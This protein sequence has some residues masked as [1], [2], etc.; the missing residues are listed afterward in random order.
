MNLNPM[1][2]TFRPPSETVKKLLI[3]TIAPAVNYRPSL[4]SVARID[5]RSLFWTV[6]IASAVRDLTVSQVSS[7]PKGC[8]S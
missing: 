8:L 3:V 2:Y 6:I 5:V 1:P 7:L 4:C